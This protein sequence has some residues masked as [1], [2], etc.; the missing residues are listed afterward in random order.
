MILAACSLGTSYSWQLKKTTSLVLTGM[1]TPV[2]GH[3]PTIYKYVIF[4]SKISF[5]EHYI[6]LSSILHLCI[7]LVLPNEKNLDSSLLSKFVPK[8]KNLSI[9]KLKGRNS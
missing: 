7:Q 9:L 1:Q 2:P 4:I 5:V 8:I 6:F 3:I